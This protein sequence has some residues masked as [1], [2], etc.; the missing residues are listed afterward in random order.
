[1]IYRVFDFETTGFPTEGKPTAVIQIGFTD[2]I[3]DGGQVSVAEKTHEFLV[4]PF[5][6]N[7]GLKIDIGAK[8]THHLVEDDFVPIERTPDVGFRVLS[9]APHGQEI[10]AFA[11]HNKEHDGHYFTGGGRP[12]ICTLRVAKKIWP[13][14]ESHSNQFLRY[15]LDLPVDRQRA[16]PP[17]GAGPDSYVTAC[18]LAAIVREGAG[19]SEMIEWSN[20][21]E[22]LKTIRFGKHKG[23]RFEDVPTDYLQWLNKQDGNDRDLRHTIRHHLEIRDAL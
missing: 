20:G 8:A 14:A 9:T 12:I 22:L 6:A 5:R 21:P 13:D 10:S 19:L 7:P 4:N 17:H 1:M 18:L 23:A 2:V 15:F 16:N 11:C 3:V